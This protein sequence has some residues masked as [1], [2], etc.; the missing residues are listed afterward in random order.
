MKYRLLYKTKAIKQ[1]KEV[2]TWSA[3]G[4][5]TD[6][7]YARLECTI[8][9][10][11]TPPPIVRDGPKWLPLSCSARSNVKIS[12]TAHSFDLGSLLQAVALL[13]T[14]W[15]SPQLSLQDRCIVGMCQNVAAA[16]ID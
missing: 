14:V 6:A 4:K 15:S 12:W 8:K 9:T 16:M 7:S 10:Q 1:S 5:Y 2:V 3:S 11:P 13:D